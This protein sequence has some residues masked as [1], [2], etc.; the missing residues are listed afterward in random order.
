MIKI[1]DDWL[2]AIDKNM[3]SGSLLL[4]LSEAF[5]I[6]NHKLLIDKSQV[7]NIDTP[8][9]SSYLQNRFQQTYFSGAMSDKKTVISGVPQG[10]VL[11]PILL[12][13]A[14]HLYI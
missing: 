11:G 2:T 1:I 14:D 13:K 5:D 12:I 6:L 4:D 3:V 10:S 9:F 7:Y 8:W